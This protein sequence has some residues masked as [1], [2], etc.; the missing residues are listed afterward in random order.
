MSSSLRVIINNHDGPSYDECIEK[1]NEV[2]WDKSSH[3]YVAAL[4]IFCEAASYR[5]GWMSLPLDEI[6]LINAWV[7]SIRGKLGFHV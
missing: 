1:L 7:T 6:N 4:G 3:L 2:G 5:K